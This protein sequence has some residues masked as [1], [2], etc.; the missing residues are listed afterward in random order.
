MAPHADAQT[1]NYIQGS[2][3]FGNL[4]QNGEM[5]VGTYN[6]GDIRPPGGGSSSGGGGSSSG[7]ATPIPEPGMFGLFALG[8]GG[9]IYARRRRAKREG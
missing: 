6:G 8:V 5:H 4:K 1:G 9:L 3:V 7:G 2:A